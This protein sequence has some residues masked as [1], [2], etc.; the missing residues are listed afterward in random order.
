MNT[1]LHAVLEATI[2]SKIRHGPAS[3]HVTRELG[4]HGRQMGDVTFGAEESGGRSR[5]V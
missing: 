2:V 1:I 5:P 4:L 3:R